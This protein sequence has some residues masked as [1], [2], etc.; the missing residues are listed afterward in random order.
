MKYPSQT[1]SVGGLNLGAGPADSTAAFVSFLHQ[2]EI[3]ESLLAVS[4]WCP[5]SAT[6]ALPAKT[7]VLRRNVEL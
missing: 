2:S 5:K 4:D 7:V 3:I 6:L 1:S